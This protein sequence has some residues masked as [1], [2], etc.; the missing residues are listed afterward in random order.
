MWEGGDENLGSLGIR[1]I[2]VHDV[3]RRTDMGLPRR[4][5]PYNFKNDRERLYAL[6]SRDVRLI[7]IAVIAA[8]AG[9]GMPWSGLFSWL[10]MR[11]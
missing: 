11:H 7:A 6:I 10:K 9:T 3:C 8:F 2:I 5:D 4:N 1:D